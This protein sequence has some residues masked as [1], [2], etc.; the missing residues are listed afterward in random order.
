MK[1]LG[2]FLTLVL[3]GCS[4][5][6]DVADEKGPT[7]ERAGD[8]LSPGATGANVKGVYDYLARYGY[9][10]SAEL[11]ARYPDFVPIVAEAPKD[12]SHF[13]EHLEQGVRA[14]QRNAGLPETGVVDAATSALMAEERCE[15]PDGY[16]GGADAIVH[17]HA[18][19][20]ES[21]SGGATIPKFATYGGNRRNFSWSIESSPSGVSVE[22][23]ASLFQEMVNEWK[24]VYETTLPRAAKGAGEKKFYFTKVDGPSRDLDGDGVCSLIKG[25]TGCKLGEAGGDVM[26]IDSEENWEF[27][28]T[29]NNPTAPYN[30]RKIDFRSVFLHELGH[31]L[32]LHHSSVTDAVMYGRTVRGSTRRVL[33]FDDKQAVRASYALWQQITAPASMTDVGAHGR[34]YVISNQP[35][36]GGFKIYRWI[37]GTQWETLDGGA[38]R[39]AVDARQ[40]AWVVNDAGNIYHRKEDNSGWRQVAGCG[41]DIAVSHNG[42]L[43]VV[44]C[45][46]NIHVSSIN[47]NGPDSGINVNA[48]WTRASVWAGQTAPTFEN[49]S[50]GL[51]PLSQG[52]SFYAVAPNGTVWTMLF[53]GLS[54]LVLDT[55]TSAFDVGSGLNTFGVWITGREGSGA[56]GVYALNIN[57]AAV[58]PEQW[59]RSQ[60]TGYPSSNARRVAVASNGKPYI[61]TNSGTFM[62]TTK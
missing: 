56:R 2:L 21:A 40:R 54:Q 36:G 15:W 44:G 49:I 6:D 8:V 53:G 37:V 55:P 35:T 26:R 3:T 7:D 10:P 31:L 13:D 38:V 14:Y 57:E 24:T 17:D 52:I 27:T 9:F 25:D 43:A 58:E 41:R 5:A 39:V 18:T 46:G 50:G 29:P 33:T 19:D 48:G 60:W 22:V 16:H 1:R 20:G 42:P 28:G 11:A 12:P 59:A 34:V 51:G 32:G 61:V 30:Q 62:T 23:V 4:T 45:D 47:L